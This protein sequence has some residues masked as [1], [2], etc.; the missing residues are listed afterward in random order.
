ML[1]LL[2]ISLTINLYPYKIF[3]SINSITIFY[4]SLNP[5]IPEE[6][7]NIFF[8][9]NLILLIMYTFFLSVFS[10]QPLYFPSPFLQYLMPTSPNYPDSKLPNPPPHNTQINPSISVQ[11]RFFKHT[12]KYL[13]FIIKVSLLSHLVFTFS[14]QLLNYFLLIF[15]NLLYFL[16]NL[17]LKIVTIFCGKDNIISYGLFLYILCFKTFLN[18]LDSFDSV[19]PFL[20]FYRFQITFKRHISLKK[21]LYLKNHKFSD[22]ITYRVKMPYPYSV[23]RPSFSGFRPPYGKLFEYSPLLILFYSLDKIGLIFRQTLL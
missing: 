18:S 15:I 7:Y 12:H 8:F 3:D 11:T 19:K 21:N 22:L 10:K 5:K 13:F 6:D 1:D 2:I 9:P 17:W 14:I 16:C 23:Q 20:H 4:I